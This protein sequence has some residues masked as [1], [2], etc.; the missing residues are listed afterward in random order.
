[1]GNAYTRD[2]ELD[3]LSTQNKHVEVLS[4]ILTPRKSTGAL[5]LISIGLEVHLGISAGVSR[6][7]KTM[8]V[9][10]S[11]SFHPQTISPRT[12]VVNTTTACSL[13]ASPATIFSHQWW[14]ETMNLAPG[15]GWGRKW[16]QCFPPTRFCCTWLS[17]SW[18]SRRCHTHP[19]L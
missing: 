15:K 1:M 7:Q 8:C 13:S 4:Q 11:C 9:M 6:W 17:F 16:C 5:P 14:L 19:T 10:Q 3:L 12:R 18:R 2:V